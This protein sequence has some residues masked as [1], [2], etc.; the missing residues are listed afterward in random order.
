[1]S[2]KTVLKKGLN[3]VGAGIKAQA[4]R[5]AEERKRQHAIKTKENE[6]YEKESMRQAVFIGKEKARRETKERLSGKK[7]KNF[8]DAYLEG[9]KKI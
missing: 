3:S 1:M 4:A 9:L 7:P 8:A 5:A 2:F 6:A